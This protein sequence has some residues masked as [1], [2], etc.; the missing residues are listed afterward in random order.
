[1]AFV[2]VPRSGGI[3]GGGGS[4]DERMK[5]LLGMAGL[6]DLGYNPSDEEKGL[7]SLAYGQAQSAYGDNTDFLNTAYGRLLQAQTA[8]STNAGIRDFMARTG[9]GNTAASAA[10][11]A[12]LRSR[13]GT[14]LARAGL[15]ARDQMQGRVGQLLDFLQGSLSR[16][17]RGRE[18]GH[19][20]KMS[21]LREMMANQRQERA[22]QQQGQADWRARQMERYG[23]GYNDPLVR[24]RRQLAER[25]FQSDGG[26]EDARRANRRVTDMQQQRQ[27]DFRAQRWLDRYR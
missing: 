19:E 6:D 2:N 22:Y 5:R 17:Q 11:A 27:S 15:Q 4:L 26:R 9:G 13:G 3:G 18:L 7:R 16:E 24:S 23:A 8:E 12:S 20:A 21:V 25:L 10:T 14:D 1:M